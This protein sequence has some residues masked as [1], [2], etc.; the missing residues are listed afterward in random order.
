MLR[1]LLS[2]ILMGSFIFPATASEVTVAVASSFQTT[3]EALKPA[4]EA[5]GDKLTIV[6]GATGKLATQITQGAPF[7]VFLS[8]DDAATK[9]I[10]GDAASEFTYALGKLAL[11]GSKGPDDLKAG[12][13]AHLAIAN[14]KLAP[15]GRAAMEVLGKLGVDTPPDRIVTAENVGQA[16]TLV[17]SGNAD[18]GFVALAQTKGKSAAVWEVPA[19]LYAPIRQNAIITAHGKD[20][21]AAAAFMEFLKSDAARKQIEDAGFGH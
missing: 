5:K 4:F 3:L 20:N 13:Y 2:L 12:N 17:E 16:F 1:T 11:Y 21:P 19:D 18:A 6:A 7:D 15:Y 14:P 8:A 10:G 9:T